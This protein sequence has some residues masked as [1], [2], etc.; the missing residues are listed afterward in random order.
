MRKLSAVF[1]FKKAYLHLNVGLE[2]L[3]VDAVLEV[4][5]CGL[6][7]GAHVG[8]LL[9]GGAGGQLG[10]KLGLPGIKEE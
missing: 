7:A 4:A 3:V 10:G 1:V 9:V 8:R 2:R 5:L 6:E